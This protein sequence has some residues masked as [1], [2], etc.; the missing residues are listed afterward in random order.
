[1]HRVFISY[2]ISDCTD[3]AGR[4][5]GDLADALGRDAVFRDKSRLFVGQNWPT[6]I[7]DS[8]TSCCVLLALIGPSWQTAA[9]SDDDRLGLLRLGDPDDWVRREITLALDAGRVVIPVYLNGVKPPSRR[10]LATVSL[11]RLHD[12]QGMQLSDDHYDA[13]FAT[14][15][16]RI[17][18][19]CP[20]LVPR[21]A[22][23]PAP[24]RR[25][26][27]DFYHHIAL[28]PIYVPRGPAIAALAAVLLS[29]SATVALTSGVLPRPAALHGMGGIGKSVLARAACDHPEVRAAFPDGILWTT[30][31]QTPNL[32][33]CLRDWLGALG[34]TIPEAA[35]SIATMAEALARALAPRACLLILDDLWDGEHFRAFPAIGPRCRLL[36]TT[37][38]ARLA[39]QF[40]ARIHAVDVMAADEAQHLLE[41]WADG[42][43]AGVSA[44]TRRAILAELGGLPLA[45]KLAGAQLQRMPATEWLTSFE[46]ARGLDAVPGTLDREG[47]VYACF[48][49]SMRVL[50][51][52]SR[53]LYTSLGI[54]REDEPIP[55]AA[56]ARLASEWLGA[57]S[58]EVRRLCHGL[59][60]L[61]LVELVHDGAA[62]VLHDLLRDMVV[63][64]LGDRRVEAH[65]RLLAA[66]SKT[67]S[68]SHWASTSDDGYLYDHLAYHLASAGDVD[69]LRSLFNDD[70]WMWARLRRSEHR[71]DGYLDDLDRFW[72]IATAKAQ[73][74]IARDAE[75]DAIADCLS[76]ALIQTSINSGTSTYTPALIA[77]AV[78]LG[79]W[80]LDRALSTLERVPDDGR[81]LDGLI[82]LLRLSALSQAERDRVTEIA[83]R[84]IDNAGWGAVPKLGS[85]GTCV[86]E[87]YLAQIIPRIVSSGDVFW[88]PEA[89]TDLV[90]RMN[91]EQLGIALDAAE[92]LPAEQDW[93]RPRHTLLAAL[94]ARV[95]DSLLERALT[96]AIETESSAWIP[97]LAAFFPRLDSVRRE[98]LVERAWQAALALPPSLDPTHDIYRQI[99]AQGL[100]QLAPFLAAERRKE[101]SS[102]CLHDMQACNGDAVLRMLVAFGRWFE[103][104][105]LPGILERIRFLSEQP[106]YFVRAV[107][108]LAERLHAAGMDEPIDIILN[109]VFQ[110]P[111]HAASAALLPADWKDKALERLL[112]ERSPEH[113]WIAVTL[114]PHLTS[115]QREALLR[116]S[117][118]T[119][120]LAYPHVA[121]KAI[122]RDLP[123]DL[124]DKLVDQMLG[125]PDVGHLSSQGASTGFYSERES[126]LMQVADKLSAEQVVR[127]LNARGRTRDEQSFVELSV[128][129]G[130]LTPVPRRAID[131]A[132]DIVLRM[133]AEFHP[134]PRDRERALSALAPQLSAT[135]LATCFRVVERD[136][137]PLTDVFWLA[138]LVPHLGDDL[139]EQALD[140]ARSKLAARASET[141]RHVPALA[142][143][144]PSLPENERAGAAEQVLEHLRIS[145]MGHDDALQATI[146]FLRPNALRHLVQRMMRNQD[147]LSKRLPQ[148]VKALVPHLAENDLLELAAELGKQ[149]ASGSITERRSR[150]LARLAV[151][152]HLP[153]SQVDTIVAAA[154]E[155][156]Q[157]VTKSSYPR[158]LVAILEQLPSEFSDRA[159]KIVL[160]HDM[161]LRTHLLPVLLP[162]LDATHRN[163]AIDTL[164]TD[165]RTADDVEAL[166]QLGIAF[167]VAL[168][169]NDY[170]REFRTTFVELL[171]A[172]RSASR[173][174]LLHVLAT[175][176]RFLESLLPQSVLAAFAMKLIAVYNEWNWP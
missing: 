108:H 99:R 11:D 15:L 123:T 23:P 29:D 59:A 106:G 22:A 128:R 43:L 140:S 176:E 17:R 41:T 84:E 95:P 79:L 34:V 13:Q 20:D 71:F 2:R 114:L 157:D 48:R 143:I 40:G 100:A 164:L 56:V 168:Q 88:M 94:A 82:A 14:L 98:E 107:A 87:V 104:E 153:R 6:E 144:L 78:D 65:Q 49:L 149:P 51:E 138:S 80:S 27:C 170:Q 132:L 54:F 105:D 63:D 38:D 127:C 126:R 136:G 28:P 122:V 141:W 124:F 55:V 160:G 162:K 85:L 74:Q 89:L 81:R 25:E 118:G 21:T 32:K 103:I 83:F 19:H 10:W 52:R 42:R 173:S 35:P 133:P 68:G 62:L 33:N 31:G 3:L 117:Y 113:D 121:W 12:L 158:D 167:E 151:L 39:R 46:G 16:A 69:T 112:R 92:V 73:D 146:P 166:Q 58:G 120:P 156:L 24:D 45:I 77:R 90:P 129:L 159:M 147:R 155:A 37:R 134:E 60:D 50:D 66:Y 8:A 135:Q 5:D 172:S 75:P 26:R 115:P 137:D 116:S 152:P 175:P 161:S 171:Y 18:Q 169:S 109:L 86:D 119:T 174:R 150:L 9:F 131:V 44:D 165:L 145:H 7:E 110:D 139:R 102:L 111:H 125:S 4:L 163:R 30:L 57:T 61:A 154:L 96:M 142:A 72:G 101:A 130:R 97:S 70:Q 47:S 93:L 53:Q 64:M 67:R 1:M 76:C 148:A 36:V 91:E